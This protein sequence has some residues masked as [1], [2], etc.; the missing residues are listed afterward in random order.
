MIG[1]LS[2]FAR[3]P[4]IFGLFLRRQ[5]LI[6]AL[7]VALAAL[8]IQQIFQ[9]QIDSAFDQHVIE[10]ASMI[11]NAAA[12]SRTPEHLKF[13]VR[14][15]TRNSRARQILIL[16]AKGASTLASSGLSGPQHPD[17]GLTLP[18]Q[19]ARQALLSGDFNLKINA[20]DG[21]QYSVLPLSLAAFQ[22]SG[23]TIMAASLWSTPGWYVHLQ[24]QLNLKEGIWASI[25]GLLRAKQGGS[26]SL[27]LDSYSGVVVI[28]SGNGAI[29]GT[30]R[31]ANACIAGILFLVLTSLFIST[32]YF[33]RFAVKR[34]LDA[35]AI[36]IDQMRAM[37]KPVYKP[38]HGIREFD[39]VATQWNDLVD[40]QAR[41]RQALDRSQN[42]YRRL[43]DSLPGFAYIC[44]N[45]DRWTMR[46]VSASAQAVLGYAPEDI[47]DN[48]V[49]AYADLIHPDDRQRVWSSAQANM[50]AHRPCEIQY[51]VI[52]AAGACKWVWERGQG[53]YDDAGT[54]V[55]IEGYIEDIT[56]FKQQNEDLLDRDKALNEQNMR[57]NAALAN[58]S[59]GLCLFDAEQRLVVC[60]ERY[61][62]MYDLSP[63]QVKPGT[64]FRHILE[65]RIASGVYNG[66]VPEDYIQERCT[67]VTEA[68]ASTKTQQL[69]DGRFIVITHQPLAGG[70]WLATHEDITALKQHERDLDAARLRAEAANRAKSAFIANTNHEIRTPLNAIVGFS[71]MLAAERL[72]PLGNPE[73]R[74]FAGL[75]ESSGRALLAIVS[76]I[77][78]LSRMQAGDAVVDLQEMNPGDAIGR[79]VRLWGRRAAGRG[80]VIG[81]RNAARQVRL[82]CDEQYLCKIIDG[83][84]SNAVKFSSDGGKIEVSLRP[85]KRRQLTLVVRDHGIGIAEEHLSELASP[86][87]QVDKCLDRS[88]GGIGLGM[89]V[90]K[91]CAD[92]LGA[93]LNI[94]S[95]PG[96]GACIKVVF[97]ASHTIRQAP[98]HSRLA[99]RPPPQAP[100]SYAETGA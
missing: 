76:T 73:Y 61:A 67:A 5:L 27:P 62:A 19:L 15:M 9:A 83:L 82:N 58:M 70:G 16:S 17:N 45:D 31:A 22:M 12:I 64:L 1:K 29:F 90:V 100:Q 97:P 96:K 38:L 46:F 20:S 66:D 49:V 59:Q 13:V 11:D 57:F 39:A 25:A 21:E 42:H 10:L 33:F 88:T 34:P 30:I 72:G 85:D 68:E 84:L 55:G 6:G 41:T 51:R 63:E 3:P 36:S 2:I 91:E 80:I 71:E 89:T 53:V 93:R 18:L 87:Y 95:R 35:Y 81:F 47:I 99:K 77:M 98:S 32:A 75:I 65:L 8:A 78:D 43:I 52:S 60:N 23:D 74:E 7:V 40:E 4:T 94:A 26:F 86:F 44:T 79:I 56:A 24:Q 28:N 37:G 50:A 92:R 14:E 48:R 69:C 54:L